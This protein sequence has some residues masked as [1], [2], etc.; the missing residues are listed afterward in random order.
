MSPNPLQPGTAGR[1]AGREPVAGHTQDT[2]TNGEEKPRKE[3]ELPVAG[4]RLSPSDKR[5]SDKCKHPSA[6]AQQMDLL[7]PVSKC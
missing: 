3:L 2:V 4:C 7:P 5:G 6:R 1:K